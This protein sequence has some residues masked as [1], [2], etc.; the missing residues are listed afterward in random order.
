MTF[1]EPGRPGPDAAP[2]RPGRRR[3]RRVAE[4]RCGVEVDPRDL[5]VGVP[6]VGVDRDPSPRARVADAL[7]RRRGWG[8]VLQQR[9]PE[10]AA[11]QDVVGGR[12]AVVTRPAILLGARETRRGRA[13]FGSSSARRHRGRR[14]S[15]TGSDRSGC[16]RR[17]SACTTAGA[18]AGAA[19]SP[20]G[21]I[22]AFV[23]GTIGVPS[24]ALHEGP[25]AVVPT[26]W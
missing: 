5:D 14:R 15:C 25:N 16:R 7:E 2:P 11:I 18:S 4:A 26:P 12:A 19:A 13:S 22:L 20:L 3:V 1:D 6:G 23:P 17:S 21:R 10:A 9:L 8:L 24:A